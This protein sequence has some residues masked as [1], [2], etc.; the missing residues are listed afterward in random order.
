MSRPVHSYVYHAVLKRIID[1]DTIVC[2]IDLGCEIW[3]RNEHCRLQGIDAP[4]VRGEERP[5]GLE[6]LRWLETI[7]SVSQSLL[8]RTT[9]GRGKGKYGRWLVEVWLPG[10][11]I[12]INELLVENGY[13]ERTGA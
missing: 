9:K 3:L 4:E 13:A 8:L 11:D 7:L 2:D 12:S 5:E 10:A 1:A 6:A